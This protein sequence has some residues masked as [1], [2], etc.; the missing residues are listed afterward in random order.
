VAEKWL[1]GR[2]FTSISYDELCF[3]KRD[4][5]TVGKVRQ[6]SSGLLV[7]IRTALVEKG[8]FWD[9]V[10]GSRLKHELPDGKRGGGKVSDPKLARA[11]VSAER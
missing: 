4:L 9:Q 5:G 10:I 7:G 11:S 1:G 3:K 6:I 2:K 8:T